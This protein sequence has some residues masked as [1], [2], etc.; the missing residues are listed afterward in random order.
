MDDSNILE[1]RLLCALQVRI[2][3]GRESGQ[4]RRQTQGKRQGKEKEKQEYEEKKMGRTG[5]RALSN[6]SYLYEVL[7]EFLHYSRIVF[8]RG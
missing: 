5:S 2:K 4:R 7:Y 3:L 6:K 8:S 1:P